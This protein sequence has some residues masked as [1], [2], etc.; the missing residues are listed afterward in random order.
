MHQQHGL[1]VART[2]IDRM[3][4]QPR[5]VGIADLGI[6]GCVRKIRQVGEARVRR[7]QYLH[8]THPID[9]FCERLYIVAQR[10]SL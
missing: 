4:A 8:W 9:R 3:N 10:V 6:V 1:A 7:S 5:T 2:F